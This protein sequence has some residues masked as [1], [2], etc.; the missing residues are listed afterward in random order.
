MKVTRT[1]KKK[2]YIHALKVSNLNLFTNHLELNI[3]EWLNS[4]WAS[5]DFF[6]KYGV[7]KMDGIYD[8]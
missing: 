3:Y 2:N 5:K 1:R 7:S 8:K 6:M 4:R